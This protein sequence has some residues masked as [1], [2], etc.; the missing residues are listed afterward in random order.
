MP[1]TIRDILNMRP[2]NLETTI[3]AALEVEVID[4][5]NDRMLRRAEEPIPAFIPLYHRPN[6][7]PRYPTMDYHH[8]TIPQVPLIQPA[9]LAM[10]PPLE[11]VR[12]V[13][14]SVDREWEEFK[15]EVKRSNDNFKDEMV[16]TM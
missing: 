15:V 16:R 13:A 10:L 9:P 2:R 1:S 6:E 7:F 4:K 8:T 11:P 14:P 12:M 3:V 5:E